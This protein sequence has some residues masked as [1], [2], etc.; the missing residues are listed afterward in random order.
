M[1]Y[2]YHAKWS[3]F[4]QRTVGLPV[5]GKAL[6]FLAALPGLIL[7]LLSAVVAGVS[8]LALLLLVV[9]VYLLVL[10]VMRVLSPRAS[11]A[12]ED[13]GVS[14]STEAGSR[15]KQVQAVVTDAGQPQAS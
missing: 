3:T 2:Q 12:P 9:P 6:L 8:I 14:Y 5:W 13:S 11:R 4:Q 1:F 15:R 7:L 10:S